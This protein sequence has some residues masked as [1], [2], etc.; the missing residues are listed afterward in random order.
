MPRSQSSDR[1]HDSVAGVAVATELIPDSEAVLRTA[2]R[3][4]FPAAAVG[5]GA[6]AALL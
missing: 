3:L 2:M 5:F 1:Y 4:R 6:A